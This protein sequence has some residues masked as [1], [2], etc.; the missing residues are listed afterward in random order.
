M[1]AFCLALFGATLLMGGFAAAQRATAPSLATPPSDSAATPSPAPTTPSS[2]PAATP[3]VGPVTTA[4][5]IMLR[6][7]VSDT[8]Y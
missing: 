5:I 3:P 8:G 7:Y 2:A 6:L 1:K 4:R